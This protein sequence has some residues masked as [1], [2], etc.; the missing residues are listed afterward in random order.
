M[1]RRKKA[2]LAA[3]LLIGA[4]AMTGCAANTKPSTT[5][6]PSVTAANEQATA[7]P[8][9]A[10]PEGEGA[11]EA[12]DGA[13]EA[14]IALRVGGEEADADALLED[15]TL[16]LPLVETAKLLGWSASEEKTD[17]EAQTSFAVSLEKEGSRISVA[18][19][20]SDNTI[21]QITW[22][23]DGLLIPVDT[24]L[25]SVGDAIYAPA[26]FFETAM[27]VSVDRVGD[28]VQVTPPEPKNT[29]NLEDA[30]AGQEG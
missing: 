29:P 7:E 19:V 5:V 20:T 11:Q 30:Q 13:D 3:G 10:Q 24:K 16:L 6:A 28:H 26:A 18:W 12:A 1:R 8:S 17:D 4:A 15:G 14:P 9:T 2:L 27:D 21:R 22:Q 25:T 23:K